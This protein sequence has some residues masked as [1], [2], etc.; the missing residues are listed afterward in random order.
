MSASRVRLPESA[1]DDPISG[2]A[3]ALQPEALSAFNQL[4]G[5]LW[6]RGVLDHP[7]KELARLRNAR[8]TNCVFCRNVRF[9]TARAEGLSE[10]QVEQI[11]DDYENSSLSD[12]QKL[13]LRYTDC[14]LTDPGGLDADL[15]A[16]MA[17]EFSPEEVVELTAGLALFMGFS[18]IAVSLGG[19]PDSLPTFEM[20][21]PE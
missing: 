19:M 21:T 18:K 12:R 17:E 11:Q 16:A 9:A 2:S 8:K 7:S 3:L 6:S 10:A 1:G 4:Y 5:T 20:P 15:K 13:I 14:F